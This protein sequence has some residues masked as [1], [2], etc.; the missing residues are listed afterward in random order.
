MRRLDRLRGMAVARVESES[1]GLM[2]A[3]GAFLA[4]TRPLWPCRSST[5]NTTGR[6]SV[7]YHCGSYVS[8][9]DGLYERNV[10]SP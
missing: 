8:I 7:G 4:V 1:K 3:V 9:Y 10:K 5:V 6:M 2:E